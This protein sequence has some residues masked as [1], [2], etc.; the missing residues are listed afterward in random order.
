MGITSI[1]VFT[2]IFMNPTV[3]CLMYTRTTRSLVQSIH[4]GSH[5]IMTCQKVWLTE[6]RVSRSTFSVVYIKCKPA[7]LSLKHAGWVW[8]MENAFW[9]KVQRKSNAFNNT[10]VSH[11]CGTNINWLIMIYTTVSPGHS[12]SADVSDHILC[13]IR[14]CQI[15]GYLILLL[16]SISAT[17]SDNINWLIMICVQGTFYQML[18]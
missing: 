6:P 1:S 2:T 18:G 13:H 17:V 15:I 7:E 11:S 16:I 3:N 12:I 5:K 4:A 9:D 10:R 8:C 14:S